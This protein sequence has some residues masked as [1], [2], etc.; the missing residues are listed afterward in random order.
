MASART[1][2]DFAAAGLGS[3][4]EIAQFAEP[5][6]A[7]TD[8]SH[9]EVQRVL[10]TAMTAWNIGLLPREAQAQAIE[11]VL[12]GSTIPEAARA[13]ARTAL[14]AMVQHH[15]ERYPSGV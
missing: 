8:G 7:L 11:D 14:Q 6:I 3:A 1:D 4:A 9:A 10:V 13:D 15:R 12:G 2:D 5:F